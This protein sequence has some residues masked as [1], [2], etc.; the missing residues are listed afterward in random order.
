MLLDIGIDNNVVEGIL[1]AVILDPNATATASE[2][3]VMPSI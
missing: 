2:I 3:S 1:T